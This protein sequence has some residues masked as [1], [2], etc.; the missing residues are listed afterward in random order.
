MKIG[1]EFY[2]KFNEARISL[3]EKYFRNH[4]II[5]IFSVHITYKQNIFLNYTKE[6]LTL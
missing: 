2:I 6:Q 3:K 4:N 5:K 1:I